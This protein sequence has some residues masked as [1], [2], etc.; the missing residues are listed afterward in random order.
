MVNIHD[1]KQH[2]LHVGMFLLG[3]CVLVGCGSSVEETSAPQTQSKDPVSALTSAKQVADNKAAEEE[4]RKERD[5]AL[6]KKMQEEKAAAEAAERKRREA[7]IAKAQTQ[8]DQIKP[9]NPKECQAVLLHNLY[10]YVGYMMSNS[11]RG[12][13]QLFPSTWIKNKTDTVIDGLYIRWTLFDYKT[14][15]EIASDLLEYNIG[16]PRGVKEET[17]KKVFER[18]KI[19]PG[20]DVV[21]STAD[22]TQLANDSKIISDNRDDYGYAATVVAVVRDGKVVA[23]RRV[24]NEKATTILND[25][26]DLEEASAKTLRKEIAVALDVTGGQM[27]ADIAKHLKAELKFLQGMRKLH[28]QQMQN[29]PKDKLKHTH[30][31]YP[32]LER[33]ERRI[34]WLETVVK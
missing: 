33:Q 20:K 4:A 9:T 21:M 29:T 30:W 31:M 8:W 32:I 10:M 11:T 3:M 18:S 15:A 1:N 13:E 7:I 23:D 24:D 27:R 22:M 25:L 12:G 34:K 16:L 26:K 6:A 19:Q 2:M 5:R 14:K 17:A 28:Q